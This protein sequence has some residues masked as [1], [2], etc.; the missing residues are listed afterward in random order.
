MQYFSVT[1]EWHSSGSSMHGKVI[2]KIVIPYVVSAN[3]EQEANYVSSKLKEVRSFARKNTLENI[4]RQ[5]LC[6]C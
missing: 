5:S 3:S 4:V 2:K 1:P 6:Y